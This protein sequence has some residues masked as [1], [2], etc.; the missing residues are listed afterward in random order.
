MH[1]VVRDGTEPWNT[2]MSK[3]WAERLT[4]LGMIAFAGFFVAETIN[5]LPTASGQ[6]P[7]FTAYTII[8]LAVIMILRS[9]FTR[10]KRFTGEV[11]FDFSYIGLKPIYVMI[12]AFFYAYCVFTVGFFVSSIVFF[13][14][15]AFM[16]GI[17]S[18]KMMGATALVLFPLMYVFFTI[19]LD[20]D[21]PEGFLL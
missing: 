16:T 7:L 4:A 14:I 9:F 15:A 1:R 21:L 12:V 18:Y 20:A 2:R 8:V 6:F 10:D 13:F 3:L 17:R 19:A 11:R 5:D